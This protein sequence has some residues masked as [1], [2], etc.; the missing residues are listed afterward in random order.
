MATDYLERGAVAG[1][2]GGLVYGLFVATVGNSFTAG[3]ETF[4]HGHGHGG[5]PVVSGLTTAVASIGG[6]VLWGLL[7]GVAVFGMAYFFLEPA[8]PGSGA[9]K[10]LA[11]AGAG[12]LTVSGAPW[13]VL[14][15]QPPGV[16]QA[17]GTETRLAWYAGL[18]AL[19]ALVAVLAG[20]AYQRTAR[21]HTAIRLGAMA[22]PL[23][24]LAV[25]VA[26]APANPVHGDV[27]AA[28]VAAYRWTVVFGQL[29]LWATIA[30]VHAWLGDSDTPAADDLDYPATAD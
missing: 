17:L 15:P 18:M 27:P 25:P 5:G 12:F 20:L 9:T 19:G 1:V 11:L 26:L 23:A 28:L 13:L 6:G 24:L 21:H 4:E 10:R 29:V 16:E 14:P 22:L 8:I 30:G 2:A 3:L 7:F